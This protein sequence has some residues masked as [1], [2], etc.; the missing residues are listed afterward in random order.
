VWVGDGS[1]QRRATHLR[2]VLAQ[3]PPEHGTPLSGLLLKRDFKYTLL[4]AADLPDST[5]LASITV[6]QQQRQTRDRGST[7]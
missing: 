5:P 7:S 3:R 1:P 4:D 6:E 2:H